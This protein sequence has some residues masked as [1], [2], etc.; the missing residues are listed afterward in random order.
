METSWFLEPPT[1][2]YFCSRDARPL[3]TAEPFA[4][5]QKHH[6]TSQAGRLIANLIVLGSGVL[7]RAVSQAYW[8]A[9]VSANAIG[10]GIQ[11]QVQETVQNL[12]HKVSKT[13]TE[14]EA[15]QILG[16]SEK[17]SWEEIMK[18]YD[19]LFENNA[20]TGTFYLQSKVFRAKE[21]LEAAKQRA[22][23]R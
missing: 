18:K 17:A 6:F 21:C 2:S 11:T 7:L 10:C 12:A 9:L 16:V 19:T 14:H 20:K 23:E 5:N 15:H 22:G 3:V 1:K 4:K 13:L 8:Q